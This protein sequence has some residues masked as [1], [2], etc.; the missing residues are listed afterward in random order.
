MAAATEYILTEKVEPSLWP[1]RKVWAASAGAAIGGALG[2]VVG[3]VLVTN[4]MFGHASPEIAALMSIVVA[5]LCSGLFSGLAGWLKRPDPEARLI[6]DEENR[7]R[8]ARRRL[9][10]AKH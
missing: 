5:G 6:F 4:R 3:W 7:P 8:T 9:R 2:T 1:T 10:P